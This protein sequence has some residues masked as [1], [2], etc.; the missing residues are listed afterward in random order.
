MHQ[1]EEELL[2]KYENG[3]YYNYKLFT[4]KGTIE[5]DI[6]KTTQKGKDYNYKLFTQK[7]KERRCNGVL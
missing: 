7:G 1:I 6:L 4:Q 2:E 5:E 3:K